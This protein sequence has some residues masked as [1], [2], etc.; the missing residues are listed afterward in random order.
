MTFL[1]L[2]ID[3][4]NQLVCIPADKLAAAI[5]LIEYVLN[6]RNRKITLH[7]IQQIT[8]F[9]NFL[10]RC[11]V[12]GRAFLRRLYNL[13][14][15]DKLLPHHH[16]KITS[17]C[18]MD[19]E[20]WR[21]FLDEPSIY[22]RP[23]LDC[24]KQTAKD[25]DMYSD[26][27]GAIG[28][29]FGAYCGQE[30]VCRCWDSEWLKEEKPSIEYLELYGVTVAIMIWLRRFSNSRI[31][32]HCDNESVCGMINKCS[33]GCRNCMVL[34]RL[35]VMEVLR[36]NVNI[37]AEWVATGDNGKADALSRMEFDRFFTLGKDMNKKAVQMPNEIWP[38]Q[39]LWM[40]N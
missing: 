37:T 39:K 22:C 38:V 35:I 6:K 36:H 1:G 19:M 24:F 28:K 31:L 16:I 14:S 4:W 5:D 2:L 25:I 40:K 26:A 27:S 30:W 21:R 34:I 18:R 11:V 33:T 20:I 7:K 3:A 17:E 32:L 12:P 15:N 9:L 13:S 29:G 10:C 8:G 23:F